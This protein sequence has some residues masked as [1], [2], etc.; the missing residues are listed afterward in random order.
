[1]VNSFLEDKVYHCICQLYLQ[2]QNEMMDTSKKMEIDLYKRNGSE[3]DEVENV[4][5]NSHEE[6]NDIIFLNGNPFHE[7]Y[8][9]IDAQSLEDREAQNLEENMVVEKKK[10][11]RYE[12]HIEITLFDSRQNKEEDDDSGNNETILIFEYKKDKIVFDCEIPE[13]MNSY[14]TMELKKKEYL[15]HQ[16]SDEEIFDKMKEYIY[17]MLEYHTNFFECDTNLFD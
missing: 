17:E 7:E 15:Y 16:M 10:K 5:N 3:E 6:N 8:G 11:K 9:S 1:M 14:F 13:R 2:F 12:Y 4:K